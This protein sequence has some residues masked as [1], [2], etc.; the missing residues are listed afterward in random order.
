MNPEPTAK[1][2]ECGCGLPAPRATANSTKWNHQKGEPQRFIRGHNLRRGGQPEAPRE[3]ACGCGELT[4]LNYKRART[5]IHGHN[6]R[7]QANHFAE[8]WLLDPDSGCHVWIGRLNKSGYGMFGN[9]LAHR[10]AWAKAHGAIPSG[11]VIDHVCSN[12]PCVNVEH[13]ELVSMEINVQRGRNAK[14]DPD[15]VRIIRASQ[16]SNASLGRRF[17]V[18]QTTIGWVRK[19]FTW[20]NVS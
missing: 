4:K 5:Y 12:P 6:A 1:L 19:G 16:E 7:A 14:L 3:C 11:L 8:R 13:L 17:G 18:S 2:C 20:R 10:L 15:K 9:K